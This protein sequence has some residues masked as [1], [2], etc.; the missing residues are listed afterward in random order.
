M[1][2][3]NK[4]YPGDPV[5]LESYPHLKQIIQLGH[6]SIRGVIK[7]KDSMFYALPKLTMKQLPE[8]QSSDVAFECY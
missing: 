8:N 2:D 4:L 5:N 3:L 6:N 7:F 1:P